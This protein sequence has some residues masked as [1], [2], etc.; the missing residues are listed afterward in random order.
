MVIYSR[1]YMS[2][3][4]RVANASYCARLLSL[5]QIIVYMFI[6]WLYLLYCGLHLDLYHFDVAK[7]TDFDLKVCIK[8]TLAFAYSKNV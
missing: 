2:V 6:S 3:A 1:G 7:F 5:V 4:C 8:T